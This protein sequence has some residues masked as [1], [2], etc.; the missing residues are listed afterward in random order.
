MAAENETTNAVYDPL[1]R[2]TSEVIYTSCYWYVVA[3]FLVSVL[4]LDEYAPS[5]LYT[6]I[7]KYFERH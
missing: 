6:I 4:T 7:S 3:V 5:L 1:F 2:S